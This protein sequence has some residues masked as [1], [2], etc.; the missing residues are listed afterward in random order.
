MR[1]GFGAEA[2]LLSAVVTSFS[3]SCLRVPEDGRAPETPASEETSQDM[4]LRQINTARLREL[5]S[6]SKF[7]SSQPD[8]GLSLAGLDL[9]SE[10]LR[11]VDAAFSQFQDTDLSG[12]NLEGANVAKSDFTG[13][14]L[15][16]ARL[17]RANISRAVLVD[18]ILTDADLENA[19]LIGCDC[20]NADFAG[21]N[22][23]GAYVAYA[24][25]RGAR[26]LTAEQLSQTYWPPGNPPI[27]DETLRATLPDREAPPPAGDGVRGP[28]LAGADLSGQNLRDANLRFSNLRDAILR[29][30]VLA[31]ADLE[32]AQLDGSDLSGTSFRGARSL[33]IEQLKAASWDPTRPPRVDDSLARRLWPDADEPLPIE[34]LVQDAFVIDGVLSWSVKEDPACKRDCASER[35]D[36]AEIPEATGVDV[37]IL[38][39]SREVERVIRYGGQVDRTPGARVVRTLNDLET[40]RKNGEYG[41]LLYSQQVPLLDGEPSKVQEWFDAGLRMVQPAYSSNLPAFHQRAA[42]KLAGGADEPGQGLTEL[43]RQVIHELVRRHMVID[44]S[45]CSEK[46]TFDI[47]EMTDVPILANHA[48]AKTLTVATRGPYLLG[49]NKSNREL[50]AI[51]ETGGVIG[52]TTVAWMLDRDGDTKGDVEDFLAHLD[53]IVKLVGVDHVGIASDSGLDGWGVDE[54]HY[55]DDVLAGMDRWRVVARRLREEYGYS[56]PDLRKILGLNF[57]RVLNQVLPRVTP[58]QPESGSSVAA[59]EVR[60]AGIPPRPF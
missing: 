44:V 45:H 22:L 16:K 17:L 40:I 8:R 50:L 55:A 15:S 19:N 25:L 30:A 58:P 46:T 39:V 43:G 3:S 26:N 23:K 60:F 29:D 36:L 18:A 4:D 21:V 38:T 9:T 53:Y 7:V 33:T 54:I 20:R 48:N 34:E 41:V 51:A 49:R 11:K 52:V 5:S 12:A 47:I 10:D 2:L 24:D 32:G 42:N 27:L 35:F 31:G 13:A 6:Q 14:R 28:Y 37:G 56:D 57:E 59:G 1:I